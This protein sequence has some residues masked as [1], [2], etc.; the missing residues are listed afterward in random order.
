MTGSPRAAWEMFLKLKTS[1]ESFGLLQLIA[2]DCYRC[3][4]GAG[5]PASRCL[6]DAVSPRRVGQFFYAAK[7][8]DILERL[9]ANP[10]HWEGKR[11]ACAG[12]LQL[13][14]AGRASRDHL[15]EVVNMLHD[16]AEKQ[17]QGPQAEQMLRIF[18]SYVEQD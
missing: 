3:A 5:A 10:E 14:L 13:Y 9:D 2:H 17:P 6:N 16:S 4:P 18:A 12:V 15:E 11:G 7:A 1:N 8:F